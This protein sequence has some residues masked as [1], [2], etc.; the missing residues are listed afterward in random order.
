MEQE[1]SITTAIL[2]CEGCGLPI[3]ETGRHGQ[4][5]RHHNARCRT[6]AWAKRQAAV[7]V[8]GDNAPPPSTVSRQEE[9]T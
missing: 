4:T 8:G 2:I 1:P 7:A 6:L 3:E 5:K 9:T